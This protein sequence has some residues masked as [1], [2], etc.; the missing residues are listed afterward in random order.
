M[1]LC[2]LDAPHD[3]YDNINLRIV[4]DF[5]WIRC[6]DLPSELQISFLLKLLDECFSHFYR[7]ADLMGQLILMILYYF[8]DP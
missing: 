8:H 4:Q 3:L 5:G 2:S 1:F 6:E 7:A